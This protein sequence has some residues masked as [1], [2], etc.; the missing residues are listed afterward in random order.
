M[1]LL[2]TIIIVKTLLYAG[3]SLVF[4]FL[5]IKLNFAGQNRIRTGASGNVEG[6]TRTG[7]DFEWGMA[8]WRHLHTGHRLQLDESNRNKNTSVRP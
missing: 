3:C 7:S 1:R 8:T 6:G 4:I 2:Y 5:R